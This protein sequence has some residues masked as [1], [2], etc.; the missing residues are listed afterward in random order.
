MITFKPLRALSV[1][2]VAR[3][4]ALPSHPV[5]AVA[6]RAIEN[7]QHARIVQMYDPGLEGYL[8]FHQ[9]SANLVCLDYL[10]V[11]SPRKHRGTKLLKAFEHHI[12]WQHGQMNI[13]VMAT[14]GARDFYLKNG[15][16]P[17]HSHALRL[18]KMQPWKAH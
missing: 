5:H 4:R 1:G 17:D 14:L 3:L 2:D 7:K 8:V 15:Y 16:S 13:S 18:L 9:A 12:G 6:M 10:Y 11:P